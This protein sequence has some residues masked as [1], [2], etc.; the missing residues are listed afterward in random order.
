MAKS[1]CDN[2][3]MIAA[4]WTEGHIMQYADIFILLKVNSTVLKKQTKQK[5][6]LSALNC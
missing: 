2:F 6:F 1:L 5:R 4:P 3:G